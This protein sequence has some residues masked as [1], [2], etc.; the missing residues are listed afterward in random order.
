[1]IRRLLVAVPALI[2]AYVA[3]ERVAYRWVWYRNGRPTRFGVAFRRGWARL[4]AIGVTPE[5]W[6]GRPPWGTLALEVRGRRSGLPR[7]V[8]VTWVS[9][10][11]EPDRY[12]V[13][14]LGERSDWVRNVRA[15]EG[16]AFVLRRGRRPV[17]LEDV[18]AEDRAPVLRAYLARTAIASGPHLKLRPDAPLAE[19]ERIAADYPV[20]RI[21][22]AT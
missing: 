19:F 17:R 15:A 21:V 9:L 20:F 10:R 2:V 16:D 13:S 4:L 1:M 8:V 6:P 22:E 3:F 18:P 12:A 14:M 11:D 7:T 5:R